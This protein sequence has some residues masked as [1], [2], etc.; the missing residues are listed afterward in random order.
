[1]QPGPELL[2]PLIYFIFFSLSNMKKLGAWIIG[3]PKYYF[4]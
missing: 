3:T 1:M 4:K 2:A